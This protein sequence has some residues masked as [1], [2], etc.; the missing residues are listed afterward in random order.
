MDMELDKDNRLW[1]SSTMSSEYKLV[2]DWI[3]N[4]PKGGGKIYRL[5]EEGTAATFINEI[6]GHDNDPARRTEITFTA[7]NKLIA[8]AIA[9]KSTGDGFI[10]VVPNIYRGTIADWIAGNFQALDPPVD[11]DSSVPDYDF[12]RGQSYYSI[13]LGA[14]PTDPAIAFILSLIHI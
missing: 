12:G 14:H 13:S 5:N 9:P 2:G 11:P 8:L 7:D 1:V 10:R 3:N 6:R 4:P